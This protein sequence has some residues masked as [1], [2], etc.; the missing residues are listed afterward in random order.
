MVT[1]HCGI[2]T[3]FSGLSLL[4]RVG[5]AT[6]SFSTNTH[7][8]REF[9]YCPASLSLLMSVLNSVLLSMG[10]P[11][12]RVDQDSIQWRHPFYVW[13]GNVLLGSER[14]Y[15][16]VS[17]SWSGPYWFTNSDISVLV[18]KSQLGRLWTM[19]KLPILCEKKNKIIYPILILDTENQF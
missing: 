9:S 15:L 1:G 16:R 19:E 14:W 4:L 6:C 10:S 5:R 12:Y 13:K 8:R 7:Q 2:S 11:L 17:W 3:A 18:Q